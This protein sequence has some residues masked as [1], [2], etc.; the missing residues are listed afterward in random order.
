[1]WSY[2]FGLKDLK[3]PKKFGFLK[4]LTKSWIFVNSEGTGHLSFR[5]SGHLNFRNSEDIKSKISTRKTGARCSV[6]LTIG[7]STK[8]KK[9][10]KEKGN[11]C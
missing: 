7:T 2:L 4:L 9:K 8:E 3:K 1:M 6:H 10:E 11:W 5:N